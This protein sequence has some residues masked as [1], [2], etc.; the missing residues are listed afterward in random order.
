LELRLKEVE[1]STCTNKSVRGFSLL[2]ATVVVAIAGLIAAFATPKIISGMREYRV[3]VAVR[4]ITDLIQRA[5]TQAVSDNRTITLRIDTGNNRAGIVMLDAAG[6]EVGVQY[7]PLPQGVQFAKP[8]GTLPAPTS[9]APTTASVSFPAKSGAT[10]IYEQ[11][12]NSRGFPAVSA[13]TVNAIYL[14][15]YN[16]TYAALTLN[17]VGGMRT[18]K[19]SGSQWLNTRTGLTGD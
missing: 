8:S 13:G 9:G 17:S 1:V 14:G 5:K 4:Q 2:E 7:I 19:W 3:N 10:N 16:K 18:W 6:A 12:F 11:G 15:S